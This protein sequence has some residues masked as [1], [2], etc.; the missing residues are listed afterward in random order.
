MER[1]VRV[2][3]YTHVWNQADHIA[4]LVIIHLNPQIS[5]HTVQ[6]RFALS[7]SLLV[8]VA[9]KQAH[10]NNIYSNKNVPYDFID[11]IKV[12]INQSILCIFF[13]YSA[14]S[15]PVIAYLLTVL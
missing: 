11:K 14:S 15:S 9:Y 13:L 7:S 12:S 4:R 6:Y 1:V 3:W 5:S 2:L 8:L 10:R